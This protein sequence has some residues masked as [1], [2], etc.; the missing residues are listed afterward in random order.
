[1]VVETVKGASLCKCVI[2]THS[3]HSHISHFRRGLEGGSSCLVG[4]GA[5]KS[6]GF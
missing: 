2:W 5:F 6:Q 3:I 1:M 4:K